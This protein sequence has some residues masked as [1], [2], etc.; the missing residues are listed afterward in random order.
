[1]VVEEKHE[2]RIEWAGI[3]IEV[4]FTRN[5]LNGT[6]HHLEL[7]ADE[8]LSVTATGYRSHFF[9]AQAEMEFDFVLHWVTAWLDQ[10]ANSKEWQEHVKR[11][12]QG[13]LFDL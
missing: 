13:D 7:R 12:R 5:W 4:T 3:S 6:A 1:M 9:P 10:A 2:A 8:P 11:Q